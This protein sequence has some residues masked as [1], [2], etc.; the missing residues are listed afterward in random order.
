M[1]PT[2]GLV[3]AVPVMSS[4]SAT[5]LGCKSLNYEPSQSHSVVNTAVASPSNAVWPSR[6]REI[7][8]KR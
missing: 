3:A 6:L 8:L 1:G 7:T 2:P 4:P 5:T